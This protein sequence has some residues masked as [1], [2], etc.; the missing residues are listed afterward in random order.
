LTFLLYRSRYQPFD[1]GESRRSPRDR[2][3]G[4][5]RYNDSRNFGQSTNSSY[6]GSDSQ[7]RSSSDARAAASSYGTDRDNRD[8]FRDRNDRDI[9]REV[10][11]REPPSGPKAFRDASRPLIDAPSG[12][13]GSNPPGDFRGRGATRGRGWRDNSRDRGRDADYR[14][15]REERGGA[16]SR[17]DRGREWGRPDRDWADRDRI[18]RDNIS[19]RDRRPSS[20]GNSRS[21]GRRGSRDVPLS[22]DVDRTRRGSRDGPSSA[23]S[24]SD[25]SAGPSAGLGRGYNRVPSRGRGDWDARSRGEWDLRGRG[26][27]DSRGRGRGNFYDDRGRR[28][29]SRSPEV[30]QRRV[31]ASRSPSSQ[32]PEVPAFG[33]PIESTSQESPGTAINIPTAPRNHKPANK[34]TKFSYPHSHHL[35]TSVKWV[36]PEQ[37]TTSL[38]PQTT[39]KPTVAH[40]TTPKPAELITTD[41]PGERP[42][43]AEAGE[44]KQNSEIDIQ[45]YIPIE[46][47]SEEDNSDS[48][49]E[50]SDSDSADEMG[51][52]LKALQKP[53]DRPAQTALDDIRGISNATTASL[54]DFILLVDAADRLF[55]DEAV[56]E[57]INDDRKPP[58]PKTTPAPDIAAP[59]PKP[60]PRLKF[61]VPDGIDTEETDAELEE[62][63][64]I[65][66]QR[67]LEDVP[68]EQLQ[69]VRRNIATPPLDSLPKWGGKPWN[70]SEILDE[71]MENAL[72]FEKQ[73]ARIMIEEARGEEEYIADLKR[74]Y[75]EYYRRYLK[76]C[77]SDDPA[78]VNYRKR[79]E[80]NAS[81]K[82]AESATPAIESRPEGRRAASRFATEHDIERVLKESE[83]EARET[84][85]RND[86][87]AKAKAASEKEAVIPNM[88][89]RKG[90]A[91]PV[92]LDTSH[93]VSFERSLA[94]L[95]FGLP[96][97]NFTPDECRI[98]EEKYLEFP[99]DFRTISSFLPGRDTKN[100]IQHYYL[101]KHKDDLKGKIRSREKGRKRGRNPGGSK[102]KSN[103]L[104]ASL[105]SRGGENE[106]G[107]DGAEGNGERRRPRRAAAPTWPRETAAS[108]SETATPAPTPGRKSAATPKGDAGSEAAS[109]KR[110]GKPSSSRD[111]TKQLKN[112]QLLAAAP[113]SI[114][115]REEDAGPPPM[116][117]NEWQ[118]PRTL[119]DTSRMWD[120]PPIQPSFSS[121]RLVHDG[122]SISGG[123]EVI[124]QVYNNQERV[125]P[126]PP[127]VGFNAQQE[128]RNSTQTSSYWSVP[129]QNDFPALLRSYGTDWNAIA[130][131]MGTKTHVMV[132]FLFSE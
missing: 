120:G 112:S 81:A 102:P 24:P 6:R 95:E 126:M 97:D 100:C 70:L 27:W 8:N 116:Q 20:P 45:E 5:T 52:Y 50:D 132:I 84:Q 107:Q 17:G 67:Q 1:S 38:E 29:R 131:W 16:H 66:R 86:R 3:P 108:E 49:D 128:Q 51:D 90:R 119:S 87:A 25:Q 44:G 30:P 15:R 64:Q 14:D 43:W 56:D 47:D 77:D 19:Y 54:I 85:E 88:L 105:G 48:D 79:L 53:Q 40:E 122:T 75:K 74:Q 124:A 68:E 22:L 89:S 61:S 65:V 106:D 32:A 58:T 99:K 114:K 115:G 39:N 9:N 113:T 127:S 57:V 10:S 103:A 73:Y 4:P 101:V 92:F 96:E 31:F 80:A 71:D 121:T 76:F 129:E 18:Y 35:P 117:V 98:F 26:E 83:R 78:A 82:R 59:V 91:R 60:V 110:K 28:G 33:T 11:S 93:L 13:R 21:P 36:R 37:T 109:G 72:E 94:I 2:S 34:G 104:I 63:L 41:F 69:T 23:S 123:L 42:V 7:Q 55:C 62:E 118:Q 111:K 12:P 125:G 130:K 46:V